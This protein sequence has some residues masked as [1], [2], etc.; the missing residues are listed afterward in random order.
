MLLKAKYMNIYFLKVSSLIK[1]NCLY[2]LYW[3]IFT[4]FLDRR[5]GAKEALSFASVGPL[6]GSIVAHGF[7]SPSHWL[8]QSSPDSAACS[9]RTEAQ[10]RRLLQ[11]ELQGRVFAL[12]TEESLRAFLGLQPHLLGIDTK[13]LPLSVV[14]I[15]T[16]F[17]F[18][19]L[20]WG[21]VCSTALSLLIANPW[22]QEGNEKE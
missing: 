15:D 6:T 1:H 2:I 5:V 18:F 11:A 3:R 7:L 22:R 13:I 17:P 10:E 21:C 16:V 12:W 19:F 14:F 9:G 4:H 20:N 8:G